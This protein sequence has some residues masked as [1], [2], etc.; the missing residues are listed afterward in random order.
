[1]SI[2]I[3]QFYLTVVRLSTHSYDEI[4]NL[5]PHVLRYGTGFFYMKNEILFLITNR[6]VIIQET[7]NYFPNMLRMP[8]HT[9]L[10]NFRQNADFDIHLRNAAVRLWREPNPPASDVVAIPLVDR[11]YLDQARFLIRAFSPANLL[12][13]E[14]QLRIGED[15]LIMG[16][17]LGE[18]YDGVYNLPVVRNG[19]I[20]SAY[21]V[22]YRDNT[23]FLV[24]AR[25]HRGTS[26]SPVTTKFK[27]TWL[28]TTGSVKRSGNAFYLL[29]INSST[30][31]L[32]PGEEP[33]GLNAVHFASIIDQITS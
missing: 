2:S 20:S 9:N 18:Y 14:I 23:Y 21:P 30:F 5:D 32:P 15:V 7:E 29:G 6:H 16:Y 19:I 4:G 13:T 26:G 22:P 10:N 11:N 31:P 25:L 12:P 33:L 1:M 24:D 28:T 27:D 3:D 17:P 8:I